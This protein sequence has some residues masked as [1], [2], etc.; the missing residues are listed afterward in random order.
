MT[1]GTGKLPGREKLYKITGVR[2]KGGGYWELELDTPVKQ[3][4]ISEKDDLIFAGEVALLSRNIVF[5][6][7]PTNDAIG[8]HFWVMQTPGLKQHLEGVEVRA[9]GQQGLLGRYPIHLHLCNDSPDTI[10]RR[11]AVLDSHQRGI[12]IHGTNK[13]RINWNVVWNSK[14]RSVLR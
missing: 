11:N 7:A 6:N 2:S 10:I 1:T 12:V 4:I 8:G 3:P 13:A 14:G 9:F 5:D